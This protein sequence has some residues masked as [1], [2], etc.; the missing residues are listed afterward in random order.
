MRRNSIPV[1]QPVAHDAVGGLD[2]DGGLDFGPES[3]EVKDDLR[4]SVLKETEQI[5]QS[6]AKV[7]QEIGTEKQTLDNILKGH[8][9]ALKESESLLRDSTLVLD[10]NKAGEHIL[11]NLQTTIRTEIPSDASSNKENGNPQD[12][13]CNDARKYGHQVRQQDEIFHAVVDGCCKVLN[14]LQDASDKQQVLLEEIAS[15][16]TKA[17]E[18]HVRCN[19]A[20]AENARRR[21]SVDQEKVR[22]MKL[23]ATLAE[24]MEKE[25][26]LKKAYEGQVC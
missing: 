2:F 19:T 8:G 24:N 13:P 17:E 7:N 22:V 16:K 6:I 3:A 18:H 25:A 14:Y 26:A 11:A 1:P 23:E 4:R 9:N 20:L 5:E 21:E 12:A 10:E 15:L